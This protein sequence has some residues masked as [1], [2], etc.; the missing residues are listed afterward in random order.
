MDSIAYIFHSSA[1]VQSGLSEILRRYFKCRVILH[2]QF[3]DLQHQDFSTSELVVFFCDEETS[4]SE[5]YLQY[6]NNSPKI[7]SFKIVNHQSKPLNAKKQ[8]SISLYN[9]PSEIY[10]IVRGAFKPS[11]EQKNQDKGLTNREIEVVKL[12]ALGFANKEIADKLFI[13]THTVISH[14]KNITE[15]LGVKSISGL[16]VYA[17]I[18][19][20]ID[21]SNINLTDLI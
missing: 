9:S 15:K 4:V 1:I 16:T 21:T 8:N 2:L 7:N 10:E 6:L 11:I 12:V 19:N 17:I 13:S 20:Y 3:N 18:N 5:S 14:R